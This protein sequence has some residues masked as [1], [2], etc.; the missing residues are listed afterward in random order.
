MTHYYK[1]SATCKIK[2]EFKEK[3]RELL[4]PVQANLNGKNYNSITFHRDKNGLEVSMEFSDT[5]SYSAGIKLDDAWKA[6]VKENADFTDGPVECTSIDEAA[7]GELARESIWYIG[8]KDAIGRVQIAD[9][10]A[11][12]AKL[13]ERRE[14]IVAKLKNAGSEIVDTD[15]D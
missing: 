12:I 6:F 2:D 1:L 10:N 7:A 3:V 5:I 8:P 9:I 14:E 13:Q 15:G 4:R 11:K